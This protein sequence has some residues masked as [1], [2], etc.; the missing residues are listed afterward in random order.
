M[1]FKQQPYSVGLCSYII[2]L[3]VLKQSGGG[4][5][6]RGCKSVLWC[7]KYIYPLFKFRILQ[8]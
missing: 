1:D 5:K 3:I 8:S 6:E 2:V 7:Y 4:T